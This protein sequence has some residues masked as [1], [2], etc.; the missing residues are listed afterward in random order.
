MD[1]KFVD[2]DGI[3]TR[4]FETGKGKPVLLIHGGGAGA[5]SWG[6]WR[7]TLPT[8]GKQVHAIAVDM[9][10]FGG[11]DKP[12]PSSYEYTQANRAKH[13]SAFIRALNL[14]E[15]V[16]IIGNSMGGCT[17]IGVAVENPDLVD[18][19]V[20]M[21]S[22]GIKAPLTDELKSIM[23]DDFTTD[24]MRKIVNGLTNPK[25]EADEELINYRHKLSIDEPTKAAYSA[26]MGW[27]AEQGGLYLDDDYIARVRHQT[28]VV[29]GKLDKVVPTSSAYR[30]LELIENSWGYI[31]PDCGHWAM[32]EHPES[33][34]RETLNF[35]LHDPA[36]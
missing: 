3:R 15:P 7:Y 23:N 35:I 6:N 30:F 13:I 18:K 22:A 12:S 2:A 28:L 31:V 17:A 36:A 4:Y 16:S 5:D 29:N 9:V 10:G 8:Y 19:V 27:L 34:A 32:M 1:S 26:V 11:T 24:G 33:F 21:G 20:L 25:F 14:S